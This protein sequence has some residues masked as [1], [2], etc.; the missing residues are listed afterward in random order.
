MNRKTGEKIVESAHANLRCR[1]D[2]PTHSTGRIPSRSTILNRSIGYDR[3]YVPLV[4]MG[5]RR[6]LEATRQHDSDTRIDGRELACLGHAATLS[7]NVE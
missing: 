2:C 4:K 7:L 6:S 3:K 5:A 1:E